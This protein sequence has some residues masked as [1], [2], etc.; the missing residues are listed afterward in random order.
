MKNIT[1]Y[2]LIFYSWGGGIWTL[3]VFI[4]NTNKYQLINKTLYKLLFIIVTKTL[5]IKNIFYE[6]ISKSYNIISH[7]LS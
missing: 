3:N 4:E 7:T 5:T 2:H 6:H 1:I